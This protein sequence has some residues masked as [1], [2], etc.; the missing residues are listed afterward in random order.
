[1]TEDKSMKTC[2]AANDLEEV[3]PTDVDC[4][5]KWG[6]DCVFEGRKPAKDGTGLVKF[7]TGLCHLVIV[8]PERVFVEETSCN[9]EDSR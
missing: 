2:G 3:L 1:M 7:A 5:G 8:L 9:T 4:D 6:W